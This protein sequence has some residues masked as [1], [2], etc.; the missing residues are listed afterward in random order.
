M[1]TQA[2]AVRKANLVLIAQTKTKAEVEGM[3]RLSSRE[4]N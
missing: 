4:T 3:Q 1:D 2:M